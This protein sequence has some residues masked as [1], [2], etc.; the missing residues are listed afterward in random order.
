MRALLI[1]T[2]LCATLT[3]CGERGSF[4]DDRLFDGQMYVTTETFRN[5]CDEPYADPTRLV[6]LDARLG[7]DGNPFA[8]KRVYGLGCANCQLHSETRLDNLVVEH[9]MVQQ[10]YA[11]DGYPSKLPVTEYVLGQLNP[12]EID[13]YFTMDNH[14]QTNFVDGK[15]VYR[16]CHV[17]ALVTGKPRP[18]MDRTKPDGKYLLMVHALGN[19]GHVCMDDDSARAAPTPLR[20]VPLDLYAPDGTDHVEVVA[21]N[22]LIWFSLPSLKSLAAGPVTTKV[23]LVTNGGDGPLLELEGNISGRITPQR[24]IDL[25][26]EYF[27]PNDR[28]GCSF[29]Y[30]LTGS[31][32]HIP[33]PH[34]TDN[35]YTVKVAGLEDQSSAISIIRNL[36]TAEIQIISQKDYIELKEPGEVLTSDSSY[37]GL[38]FSMR[39]QPNEQGHFKVEVTSFDGTTTAQLEGHLLPPWIVYEGHYRFCNTPEQDDICLNYDY[40]V[41][42]RARYVTPDQGDLLIPAVETPVET[43]VGL[44]QRYPDR[45]RKDEAILKRGAAIPGKTVTRWFGQPAKAVSL[46]SLGSDRPNL[47]AFSR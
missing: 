19:R 20:V 7:F 37:A 11:W 3:A 38:W 18:V 23:Y 25:Q 8:A 29:R 36:P 46:Q 4:R 12:D 35:E 9:G 28:P 16:P 14:V 47:A 30:R 31:R 39:L 24:G 6:G 21:D 34:A 10:G 22:G 26:I 5:T 41:V 13:L 2:S 40:N 15:A 45:F 17:E 42:G 33:Q 44:L 27:D 32:K 43:K 1:L